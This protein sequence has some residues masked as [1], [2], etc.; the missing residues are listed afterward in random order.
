MSAA[1]GPKS[2]SVDA[3]GQPD[4]WE[5]VAGYL[6]DLGGG[7][8]TQLVVSVPTARL[9]DVHTAL[10]EAL[11]APLGV[12]YRQVV[13]RRDPQPEGHPPRDFVALELPVERV[14][15]ALRR[16][17][18]VVHHDARCELWVRGSLGDQVILDRD[19]VLFCQ[20]DDPSFTDVL[21]ARGVPSGLPESIADRDYV[22]HWFH[23]AA[24]AHEDAL[25]R[26][27]GLVEVPHRG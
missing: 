11:Q 8:R 24:D 4:G 3:Q 1:V 17:T 16:H 7:G 9:L 12:L 5:P 26:E 18:A 19:G 27:L 14:V 22:K 13:D 10:L 15:R 25:I 6:R 2:Q 20:P 21:A 23:A